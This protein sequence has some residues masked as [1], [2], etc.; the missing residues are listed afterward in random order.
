M[1][2][3]AVVPNP[4]V[5]AAKWEPQRLTS[6]G[7]GERR[8]YFIHLPREATIRIYTISGYHVNTIYHNL[9]NYDGQEPWDL[10]NKEGLD[11]APGV[12][13]YH[14]ESPGLPDKIDKFA[15]IK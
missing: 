15:I 11:V 8:I 1:N 5:G 6:S 4:Y 10:T 9:A 14:V 13:I 7:R 12:Y 3:V 2:L